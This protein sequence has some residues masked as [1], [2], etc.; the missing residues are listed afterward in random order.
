MVSKK[1][2]DKNAEL[3]QLQNDYLTAKGLTPRD[4]WCEG[5]DCTEW[6]NHLGNVQWNSVMPEVFRDSNILRFVRKYELS[7]VRNMPDCYT[8]I[9]PKGIHGGGTCPTSAV[10]RAVINHLN[11]EKQNN[12]SA[13]GNGTQQ[14]F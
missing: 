11:Q 9:T 3:L 4:A 8:A 5:D 1:E 10:L 13:T 7:L 2:S 12:E 6:V 14:Q